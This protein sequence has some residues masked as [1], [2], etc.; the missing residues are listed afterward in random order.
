MIRDSLGRKLSL[1][2]LHSLFRSQVNLIQT[3]LTEVKIV[4]KEG[5]GLI[6]LTLENRYTLSGL[7]NSRISIYDLYNGMMS[8]KWEV[9]AFFIP[10]SWLILCD[11][12]NDSFL[13][14]LEILSRPWKNSLSHYIMRQLY[15]DTKQARREMAWV[16]PIWDLSQRQG[17]RSGIQNQPFG[18]QTVIQKELSAG[19][20]RIPGMLWRST[21]PFCL[22]QFRHDL[23]VIFLGTIAGL[24]WLRSAEADLSF[25]RRMDYSH[26]H[27][28][29]CSLP[30]R[31]S[32]FSR[33][34]LSFGS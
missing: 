31:E 25:L 29:P 19:P 32:E 1:W 2:Q 34:I 20:G 4:H 24:K 11:L 9:G 12:E 14:C 21:G 16:C 7:T 5:S 18:I 15:A 17:Y 28:F 8:L 27:K 23:L 30:R 6:F 13:R 10:V 26:S 33:R 22:D 3:L